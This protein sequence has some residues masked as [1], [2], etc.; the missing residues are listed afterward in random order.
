MDFL[1]NENFPVFSI[2]LLRNAGHKVTSVIEETPG[3][4][5]RNVL[6]HAHE[7]NRIVLTFD[8]DYSRPPPMFHKFL[9]TLIG[10][11]LL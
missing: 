10:F 2:R 7:E 3:D 6:K 5:D 8:R 11:N 9:L 4:K 1:A